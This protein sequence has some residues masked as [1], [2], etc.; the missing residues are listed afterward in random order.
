[1]LMS[2]VVQTG[3]RWQRVG[4]SRNR[5]VSIG[6]A[7]FV[8]GCSITNV[9]CFYFL[10]F[11]TRNIWCIGRTLAVCFISPLKYKSDAIFLIPISCSTLFEILEQIHVL[12]YRPPHERHCWNI[13]PGPCIN[14][15]VLSNIMNLS[16]KIIVF[17]SFLFNFYVIFVWSFIFFFNSA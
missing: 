17:N 9:F 12:H 3:Q 4:W 1:M 7:C 16:F 5:Q 11:R 6:Q 10:F 8:F 14:W 2:Y 13:E 15:S